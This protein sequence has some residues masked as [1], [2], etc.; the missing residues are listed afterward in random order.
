MNNRDHIPPV[1]EHATLRLV[2]IFL[3]VLCI[4]FALVRCDTVHAAPPSITPSTATVNVNASNVVVHP[5]ARQ[6]LQTF[7]AA[8]RAAT[9]PVALGQI[10]WETD[11]GNLWRATGT[12]A[13]NWTAAGGGGGTWGSITGTLASQTDLDTALGLKAPLLSPSFTT[14]ALGVA[15]A[16]SLAIGAGSA[17]TSSGAGGNLGTGAFNPLV[18]PGGSTTQ[19]Q[20][21]DTGTFAGSAFLTLNK[22]NGD[23]VMSGGSLSLGSLISGGGSLGVWDSATEDYKYLGVS[24][25]LWN[26]TGANGISAAKLA[27]TGV[28][29]GASSI[30]LG[31]NGGTGGGVVLKGS[32]SGSSTINV[33]ATGDL[34]LGTV[35]SGTWSGSFGAVSGANLTNLT[36]ANIT[37]GSVGTTQITD[38]TL[39]NADISGS[40]AIA[41]SKL[42][43]DP[44][45]RANHTGTQLMSTIS[46]AG[47][48]ATLSTVASATITDSSIVNVDVSPSAAI[49]GT[50]IAGDDT[51]YDATSWNGNTAVA[52]KNAI[53]D[54]IETLGGGGG[55]A[56]EIDTTA[57]V[58]ADGN[59]GTGVLG[60]PAH[61]Y[62]TMAAAY[63]AGARTFYLGYGTFAG[64]NIAGDI[65]IRIMGSGK[66]VTNVTDIKDTSNGSQS[67]IIQ[68]LGRL[69][70][71]VTNVGAAP[72]QAADAVGGYGGDSVT[73]YNVCASTVTCTGGKGGNSNLDNSDA[74]QGGGSG[75]GAFYGPCLVGVLYMNGGRGGDGFGASDLGAT[76]GNGG[77]LTVNS[78]GSR[79]TDLVL[80][81]GQGGDSSSATGG[82]GGNGGVAYV[83]DAMI[84]SA[85]LSGA[86]PGAGGSPSNG[87]QSLIIAYHTYINTLDATNN[88]GA[89]AVISGAL[90]F[91]GTIIGS[92]VTL[93]S[94]VSRINGVS[95]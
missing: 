5:S 78:G 48:L 61:P 92:G 91:V 63:T 35:T 65:N 52:T 86:S 47:S 22:V 69:S 77:S 59:D 12:S 40:A 95:Y 20:F 57:W 11:T 80:Q 55:T 27:S 56:I 46:N 38:G 17:I 13:G 29:T 66:A 28:I 50:K 6:L 15:T 62:L 60:D 81:G 83:N 76:G 43:T 79:I 82:N 7:T 8:T 16:T 25:G 94:P 4:G 72:P 88:D 64:L 10:G 33:S 14:P 32:T 34:Q 30:T 74:A 3:I 19:V 67:I 53:R 23:V 36:G 87:T 89:T 39:V 18:T 26:F 21:N 44:L 75:N 58:E 45:P 9:V 31:T 73:L 93:G 41:L 70:F 51:A 90:N 42:A 1:V 2:S 37:S 49:A 71:T 24:S 54:K 85:N 84:D 68:D